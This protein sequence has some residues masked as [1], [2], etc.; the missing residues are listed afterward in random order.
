MSKQP[1]IF[2]DKNGLSKHVLVLDHKCNKFMD[3]KVS[4]SKEIYDKKYKDI[5]NS[6][7]IFNIDCCNG[8]NL[9]KSNKTLKHFSYSS[10]KDIPYLWEISPKEVKEEYE[11]VFIG[12]KNLKPKVKK[13]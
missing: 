9:A 13:F 7:M 6:Y 12:F 10:S 5:L 8:F 3:I 2:L 4:T 11:Q 1:T